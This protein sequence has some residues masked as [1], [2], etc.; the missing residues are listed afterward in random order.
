[1]EGKKRVEEEDP[2]RA[3]KPTIEAVG[4]ALQLPLKQPV[5]T[6]GNIWDYMTGEDPEFEVRDLFFVKKFVQPTPFRSACHTNSP[7]RR[8]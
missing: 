6:L 4:Y 5:I 1:M 3:V 2:E 8:S 7:N